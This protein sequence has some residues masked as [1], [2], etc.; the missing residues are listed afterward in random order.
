MRA[1]EVDALDHFAWVASLVS[2]FAEALLVQHSHVRGRIG[3]PDLDSERVKQRLL[4][5]QPAD[6]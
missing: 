3:V 2:P 1:V 5:G 6:S 4:G